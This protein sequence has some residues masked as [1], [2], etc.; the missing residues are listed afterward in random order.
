MHKVMSL[1]PNISY[2]WLSLRVWSSD[3]V[4]GLCRG[5]Q[6][7]N[8]QSLFLCDNHSGGDNAKS[9]KLWEALRGCLGKWERLSTVHLPLF[10][11]PFWQRDD[12]TGFLEDLANVESLRVVSLMEPRGMYIGV[13]NEKEFV[14]QFVKDIA[15]N[16]FLDAIHLV[17]R[18]Q[19]G[20]LYRSWSFH[21]CERDADQGVLRDARLK[22]IVRF[23]CRG[24]HD[25]NYKVIINDDEDTS[26]LLSEDTDICTFDPSFVALQLA[27]EDVKSRIWNE[28]VYYTIISTR[29]STLRP[30]V[31]PCDMI[32]L[33]AIAGPTL[34][35]FTGYVIQG[36]IQLFIGC[37]IPVTID[38]T[39][40]YGFTAL[41]NLQWNSF[42]TLRF[43]SK[44]VP[45]GALACLERLSFVSR[46][47]SSF[48]RLLTYM[49][50]PSLREFAFKKP[51][52]FGKHDGTVRRDV[53]KFLDVH[54]QKL[55]Y[56]MVQK[57]DIRYWSTCPSLSVINVP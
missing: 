19:G 25:D 46:G 28:I 2:L 51:H 32:T 4:S 11:P 33:A 48:I 43:K 14:E 56:L 30:T 21:C 57:V 12:V 10:V 41:R 44:D 29:K 23:A 17:P 1:A 39:S 54:G 7:A 6:L 26:G 55:D 47:E 35:S 31:D 49:T 27:P 52:W 37:T 8:P 50:L 36:E 9:R 20:D 18:L 45:V 3:N 38:A 15:R 40:L 53:F 34:Q 42:I 22:Q 16:P 13:R 5:L 24:P